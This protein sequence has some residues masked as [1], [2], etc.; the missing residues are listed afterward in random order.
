MHAHTAR[1]ACLF[2]LLLAAAATP[3]CVAANPTLDDDDVEPNASSEDVGEASEAL[4]AFPKSIQSRATNKCFDIP[5]GSTAAGAAINQ[6]TCHGGP[7]QQFVLDSVPGLPGFVR[8]RNTSSNLCV[9]PTGYAGYSTPRMSLVQSTCSSPYANWTR[10]SLV[11]VS[12]GTRSAFRWAYDAAYCIDVPGGSTT[13]GLQLQAY[14]CHGG[15]NQSFEHRPADTQPPVVTVAVYFHNTAG[16]LVSQFVTT[17]PGPN[18]HDLTVTLPKNAEYT[19]FRSGSDDV[20]L[21][22]LSASCGRVDTLF[23]NGTGTTS[24]PLFAPGLLPNHPTYY[25]EGFSRPAITSSQVV[26]ETAE[27]CAFA[28]DT[29]QNRA[30]SPKLTVVRQ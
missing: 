17:A 14:P 7:A 11:A 13:D 18:N 26:R 6:F 2:G 21:N 25:I 24:T 10:D 8:I 1:F 23:N 20:G 22:E 27:H 3:A 12:G 29:S 15:I 5:G 19:I 9:T 30:T 16:D 4:S 28:V